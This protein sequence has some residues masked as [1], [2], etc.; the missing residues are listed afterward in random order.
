MCRWHQVG[1]NYQHL[2]NKNRILRDTKNLVPH[3]HLS[4]KEEKGKKPPY[5]VPVLPAA[6]CRHLNVPRTRS[7]PTASVPSSLILSPFPAQWA[8]S[9]STPRSKPE[10]HGHLRVHPAPQ[11]HVQVSVEPCQF[12]LPGVSSV[13]PLLSAFAALVQLPSSWQV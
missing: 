9:S 12:Y 5:K 10:P 13:H 6:T 7:Q 1:H 2:W 8:V 4:S 3:M 11:P